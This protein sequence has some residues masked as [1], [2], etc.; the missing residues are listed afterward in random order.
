MSITATLATAIQ[1]PA[2]RTLSGHLV[3]LSAVI[4]L[5]C[6]GAGNAQRARGLRERREAA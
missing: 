6:R 2:F 4:W 5:R 1:I 3:V